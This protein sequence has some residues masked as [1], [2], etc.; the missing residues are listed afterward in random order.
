MGAVRLVAVGGVLLVCQG[1]YCYSCVQPNASSQSL[2]IQQN[3]AN[4]QMLRDATK[5]ATLLAIP[6]C[7][8]APMGQLSNWAKKL[9][10]STNDSAKRLRMQNKAFEIFQKMYPNIKDLETLHAFDSEY[11]NNILKD[12][13]QVNKAFELLQKMHPDKDLEA[14]Q[15]L[16]SKYDNKK[17]DQVSKAFGFFQKVYPDDTKYAAYQAL[18]SEYDNKNWDQVNKPFEFFQ[19]VYPDD[20]KSA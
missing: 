17:W 14:L 4:V 6:V 3:E 7:K 13:D 1:I 5:C 9:F 12:W 15:A 11:D 2:S 16:Y 19:K 10:N 8:W 20:T 18:K